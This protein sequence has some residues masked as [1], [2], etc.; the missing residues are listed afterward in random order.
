MRGSASCFDI[1]RGRC[2]AGCNGHRLEP[3]PLAPYFVLYLAGLHCMEAK[4]L[5]QTLVAQRIPV[6]SYALGYLLQ[7]HLRAG[8][9]EKV[10][11]LFGLMADHGCMPDRFALNI[12]LNSLGQ[13]GQ[14]REAFALFRLMRENHIANNI[15]Y[16]VL[17][18][19][20]RRLGLVSGALA[21]KADMDRQPSIEPDPMTYLLL[22]TLL[23]SVD[24]PLEMQTLYQEMRTRKLPL[25]GSALNAYIGFLYK[26]GKFEL[27]LS[28]YLDAIHGCM[29]ILQSTPSGVPA[30]PQAGADDLTNHTLVPEEESPCPDRHLSGLACGLNQDPAALRKAALMHLNAPA[31]T[32]VHV[33]LACTKSLLKAEAVQAYQD[34]QACGHR[35]NNGGY[36]ALIE[37]CCRS[38]DIARGLELFTE[39]RRLGLEPNTTTYALVIR[40]IATL[41]ADVQRQL[42]RVTC[43]SMDSASG[44]IDSQVLQERAHLLIRQALQFFADMRSRS[45]APSR[46]VY[47]ALVQACAATGQAKN[48]A[49]LLIAHETTPSSIE[50]LVAAELVDSLLNQRH[51]ETALRFVEHMAVLGLRL[52]VITCRTLIDTLGRAKD[53]NGVM[54]ICSLMLKHGIEINHITLRIIER[55]LMHHDLPQHVPSHV[56]ERAKIL[57]QR[58]RAG[59]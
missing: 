1:R 17:L 7:A 45:H 31:D 13:M 54:R 9:P 29:E 2:C 19:M 28:V 46:M 36:N 15:T 48:L 37:L 14:A 42:S 22:M 49:E 4:E 34:M 3:S 30:D 59:Q 57:L 38:G 44:S 16:N 40:D 47:K 58:L 10:P 53:A 41:V 18:S 35:L 43:S 56:E 51:I 23:A 6:S 55:A 5:W 25:T 26:R 27:V 8:E 33:V 24:R 50:Q 52:S 21:L 32:F 12:L 20:C 39:M 11:I